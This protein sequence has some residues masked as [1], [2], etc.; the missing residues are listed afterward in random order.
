MIFVASRFV[1]FLGII[2]SARFVP[3]NPG[4]G[5]WNNTESWCRY[6][7]RF[8]TGWY[9]TILGAGYSYNGDDMKQQNVAFYPLYPMLGRALKT[10]LGIRDDNALLLLSS[11]SII[12]AI[13][14][15][16]KLIREVFDDERAFAA[17]AF[18]S[19]FP[20]SLFFTAAYTESLAFLWIVCFFLLLKRARYFPAACCAG[21]CLATRSVGLVLMLPL[22]WELWMRYRPQPKEFLWRAI[23]YGIV[24]TSGL[25]LFMA[26]LWYA[27]KRP[28]AFATN[29]RAWSDGRGMW[30]TFSEAVTLK[31]FRFLSRIFRYG[32][33]PPT[34]DP[35]L[36]LL[37]LVLLIGFWKR[38]PRSFSL[39]A[40]G[41]LLLPYLTHSGGNFEMNSFTRY[42]LPAFPVFI[43]M[44]DVCRKRLWL[45][46]CLIGIFASVLFYFTALFAQWYW[47]E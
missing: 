4:E 9:L 33:S 25:W 10:L 36:F 8:D 23:A 11:L 43:I 45:G 46:M 27:F 5:Y 39:F 15:F 7:L 34:L 3:Q 47:V 6:L 32:V 24:A 14:L 38:L 37:F 12:L 40:L 42:I 21:L 1:V 18:L 28:M 26:Y 44:A 2:F 20:S 29:L 17:I 41:V 22:L 13:L 30:T 16:F 35:W 31:P 19:F